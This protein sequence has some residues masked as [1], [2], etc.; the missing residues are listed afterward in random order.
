MSRSGPTQYFYNVELCMCRVVECVCGAALW[1][2]CR[3]YAGTGRRH[4]RHRPIST[5]SAFL[6][7]DACIKYNHA[8]VPSY[9][10]LH[11]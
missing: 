4:K 6:I 9:V 3:N 8:T 7:F 10:Y 2:R 1:A 5:V 11:L